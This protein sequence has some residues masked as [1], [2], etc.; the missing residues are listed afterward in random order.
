MAQS[1]DTC[2]VSSLLQQARHDTPTCMCKGHR[3][4][5]ERRDRTSGNRV[6]C[7][8]CH[9]IEVLQRQRRMQMQSCVCTAPAS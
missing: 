4:R 2:Y 5:H 3:D 8:C 1:G 7:A 9:T 6:Q